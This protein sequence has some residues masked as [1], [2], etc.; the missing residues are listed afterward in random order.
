[1]NDDEDKSPFATDLRN[2]GA[3]L[4]DSLRRIDFLERVAKH[5][6]AVDEVEMPPRCVGPMIL[7]ADAR[8]LAVVSVQGC[9]CSPAACTVGRYSTCTNN[10]DRMTEEG[11]SVLRNSDK[12]FVRSLCLDRKIKSV[13]RLSSPED[14][15][16]CALTIRYSGERF[17]SRF[18]YSRNSVESANATRPKICG[19]RN[20]LVS[21]RGMRS[22]LYVEAPDSLESSRRSEGSETEHL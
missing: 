13:Y 15:C 19:Q 20:H 5:W 2:R 1:M 22:L 6:A 17:T 10:L 9:P 3:A 21:D 8:V 16:C 18:R 7:P 11:T 4:A 12:D 14:L